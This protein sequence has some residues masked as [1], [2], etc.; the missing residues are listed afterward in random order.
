MANS[1]GLQKLFKEINTEK[2]NK[3]TSKQ[4]EILNAVVAYE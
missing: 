3:Q 4:K 2:V 1:F